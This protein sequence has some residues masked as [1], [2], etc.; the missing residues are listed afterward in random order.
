MNNLSIFIGLLLG[1]LFIII[2][3][4]IIVEYKIK[5]VTTHARIDD[6]ICV[7]KNSNFN[8]LC[9][10]QISYIVNDYKYFARIKKYIKLIPYRKYDTI[11]IFYNR[12]NPSYI[13]V[14]DNKY[15][16][17]IIPLLIGILI[18]ILTF[19]TIFSII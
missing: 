16:Y 17:G 19:L 3:I 8:Y 7:L 18:L 12:K 1:I 9:D 13:E 11:P 15:L 2:G 10:L 14:K 4:Y 5:Y 6:A